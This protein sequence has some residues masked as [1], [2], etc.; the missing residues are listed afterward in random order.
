MHTALDY[1]KLLS[2]GVEGLIEKSRKHSG[3]RLTS[4]TVGIVER[5]EFHQSCVIELEGV[6]TLQKNY[7]DEARRMASLADGA[8]RDELFAL[9]KTL[10]HVPGKARAHLPRGSAKAC[11][12]S[13]TASTESTPPGRPDQYLLPYYR[14]DIEAGGDSRRDIGAG[15]YRQLLSPVHEQHERVGGWPA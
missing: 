13:F 10:D 9:A 4:R 11:I 8:Q 7:A 6:L 1:E 15:A 5:Y 3:T 2:L 12:S 14:R